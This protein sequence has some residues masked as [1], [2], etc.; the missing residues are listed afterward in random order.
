M[1]TNEKWWPP[2]Y[3]VEIY[4]CLIRAIKCEHRKI[5]ISEMIS[6]M[7]KIQPKATT[8]DSSFSTSATCASALSSILLDEQIEIAEFNVIEAVTSIIHILDAWLSHETLDDSSRHKEV[9][10]HMIKLRLT[11]CIGNKSLLCVFMR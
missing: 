7:E 10:K 2:L 8:A 9:A 4:K 11:A 6:Y 1:D 3:G 5:F